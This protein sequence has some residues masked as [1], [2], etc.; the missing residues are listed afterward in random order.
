LKI[1]T[2][3]CIGALRKKFDKLTELKADI[4]IIQECEDP[5][6]TTNRL[7]Q[8][9]A[10][11]H[12]WMGD[13]K[14]KGIGIFADQN[15]KLQKL[16]WSNAFRDHYVNHFLPCRI[17]DQFNILGVWTHR[18]NSPNFAYIGQ[19]W[20]YMQVNKKEFGQIII[21][22]DFNSNAVWDQW[23]R[24]WNHSDVVRDLEEMDIKS[25]YHLVKNE[26]QGN[27]QT[28]TFFLQRKLDKPYHI[29]Y[30]F[31]NTPILKKVTKMKIGSRSEWIEISDH[32]PLTMEFGDL[33]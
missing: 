28:P 17:N 31:C 11:N 18:N 3:N 6:Q 15:I 32:L 27:E 5:T 1:V 10:S 23:D 16:D 30:I 2:W 24:W 13:S 8:E 20:K 21:A 7:Y 25:V 33:D 9:W 29:D 12:L 19:F 26:K 14:N 4:Y 22:G